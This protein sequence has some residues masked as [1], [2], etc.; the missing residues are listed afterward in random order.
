MGCNDFNYET[1][2]WQQTQ[3][4]W[5][6]RTTKIIGE[7]SKGVSVQK[8]IFFLLQHKLYMWMGVS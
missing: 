3:E 4:E 5:N 8:H 2:I 6:E 1:E 7:I